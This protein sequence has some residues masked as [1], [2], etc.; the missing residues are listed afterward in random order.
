MEESVIM[1]FIT[2]NAIETNGIRTFD[3]LFIVLDAED[4]IGAGMAFPIIQ[5]SEV[6]TNV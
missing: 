6:N 3:N 2:F 4:K 5:V 1:Q